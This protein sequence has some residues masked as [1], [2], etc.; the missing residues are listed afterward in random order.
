MDG[1]LYQVTRR[2][3]AD[4]IRFSVLLLSFVV[5]LHLSS[6]LNAFISSPSTIDGQTGF[7]GRPHGL[8]YA[9]DGEGAQTDYG[10]GWVQ[11]GMVTTSDTASE[12]VGVDQRILAASSILGYY[13]DSKGSL[14]DWMARVSDDVR[15]VDLNIPGTHDAATWNYTASTQAS[16]FPITGPLPP[17]AAFQCQTRSLF[18]MLADGIRFFDLRIGFLPDHDRLG[19][20]HASALL[21]TQASLEDVLQGF[22]KWLR[23]HPTETV[24]MSIKVD[25]ATFDVPPSKKQASSDKLQEKIYRL[26]VESEDGR[27]YWVQRDSEL[28]T[29]GES[30]GKLIFIQRIDWTHIRT[31]PTYSA[32]GIP[33]PPSSFND[34]DA[35]FTITYNNA[36]RAKVFVEDYYNIQQN[37]SS[38]KNK[39]D[40]KIQAVLDH[41][42][43]ANGREDASDGLFLTFSSGGALLN[44][45]PVT[46]QILALGTPL[47]RG[48]NTRLKEAIQSDILNSQG[49]GAGQREGRRKRLGIVVL[50]WYYQTPGLVESIIEAGLSIDEGGK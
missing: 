2:T 40:Q 39:V 37:P 9:S 25:N 13:E 5:F 32:I 10:E 36:T 6:P 20:F 11:V 17:A 27:K 43:M 38:V 28:G 41:L 49:Q 42:S 45:P 14:S 47:V 1:F 12:E 21:S 15:L 24:L 3:K 44:V 26:L 33:L 19:F 7:Q 48:V 22:Y 18:E 34:N 30:R 16:L 23:D 31:N 46:P 35:N 4:W 29:V 50:D 8:I